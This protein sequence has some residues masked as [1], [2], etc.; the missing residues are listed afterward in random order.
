MVDIVWLWTALADPLRSFMLNV[1]FCLQRPIFMF[2]VIVCKR[3]R[4]N[5]PDCVLRRRSH[6]RKNECTPF[7]RRD[8][9]LFDTTEYVFRIDLS[10]RTK[11]H[12]SYCKA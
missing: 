2:I 12:Q 5:G 9:E 10:R 7:S 1:E 11:G 8:N 3:E 6:S 4:E